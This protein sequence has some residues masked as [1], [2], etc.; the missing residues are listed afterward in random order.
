V[1][2]Y[3]GEGGEWRKMIDQNKMYCANHNDALTALKGEKIK[4]YIRDRGNDSKIYLVFESG[5]GIWFNNNHAFAIA[6]NPEIDHLIAAK[7]QEYEATGIDLGR[8]LELAGEK[9]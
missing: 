1:V 4:G 3:S 5:F 8:I 6:L 9:V 2:G 7:K